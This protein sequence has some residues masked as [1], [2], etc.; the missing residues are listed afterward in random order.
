[1]ILKLPL[2]T[3]PEARSALDLSKEPEQM[4]RRYGKTLYG[5]HLLL[6]RRLVEAGVKLVTVYWNLMVPRLPINNQ[7]LW[8][9]HV[10]NFMY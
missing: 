3:S 5:Q 9:T 10:K 8:D 1:M 6:A 2:I 7:P 4:R